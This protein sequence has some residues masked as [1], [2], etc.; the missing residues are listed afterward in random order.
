MGQPSTVARRRRSR[1]RHNP[2]VPVDEPTANDRKVSG[3][4]SA[5]TAGSG[6]GLLGDV[7]PVADREAG[8]RFL[9]ALAD[10]PETPPAAALIENRQ[11][12]AVLGRPGVHDGPCP[13]GAVP[14]AQGQ[15][16]RPEFSE[17]PA[18]GQGRT[19]DDPHARR[20]QLVEIDREATLPVRS[21]SSRA[22]P[23]GVQER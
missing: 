6:N 20:G 22:S 4:P 17:G 21:I 3:P 9:V 14:I 13:R 23:P 5:A 11:H 10:G 8:Q 2:L 1:E 19:Y 16:H 15:F 12:Q 7:H 18:A